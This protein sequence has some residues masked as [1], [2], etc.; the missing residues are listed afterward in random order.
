MTRPTASPRGAR[1]VNESHRRF[2]DAGLDLLGEEGYSALKLSRLCDRVGVTTGAFYHAFDG[3]SDF[4]D[5]L[6]EFWYQE[7]TADIGAQAQ[8]ETDPSRRLDLLIQVAMGLRHRSESAIRTWAGIDP[9][10]RAVQDRADRDRI[11]VVAEAFVAV[12]GDPD[13]SLRLARAAF[14]M[15][16]GYEQVSAEQDPEALQW[17][18]RVLRSLVDTPPASWPIGRDP[19]P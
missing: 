4:T 7:R 8:A 9:K 17:A 12:N 15:L 6:L 19:R 3:W 1:A 2:F 14:Y 10:V 5:R 11:E 13:F 16:I 18:L